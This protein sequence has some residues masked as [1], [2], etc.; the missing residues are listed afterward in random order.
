MCSFV[1]MNILECR[2][3]CEQEHPEVV[4]DSVRSVPEDENVAEIEAIQAEKKII[5]STPHTNPHW[6][7]EIRTN[8]KKLVISKCSQRTRQ[9]VTNNEIIK[10]YTLVS[11]GFK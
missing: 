2:A 9:S 8:Y 1:G 4:A 5:T 6:L 3:H 7:I 11:P 10:V